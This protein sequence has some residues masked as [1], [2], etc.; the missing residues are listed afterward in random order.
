MAELITWC[1]LM[2]VGP[3]CAVPCDGCR[4]ASRDAARA[5]ISIDPTKFYDDPPGS[6]AADTARAYGERTPDEL[7]AI[8]LVSRLYALEILTRFAIPNPEHWLDRPVPAR[9]GGVSR[10]LRTRIGD[11]DGWIC[12]ICTKPVDPNHVWQKAGEYDRNHAHPTVEHLLP[13]CVGGTD[14]PENLAIAHYGCNLR[15]MDY[16]EFSG[17]HATNHEIIKAVNNAR[18]AATIAAAARAT[19]SGAAN[20]GF[21][22][23]R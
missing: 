2:R 18:A 7:E 3:A 16:E 10:A 12:G 4:I 14:D 5:G 20:S 11:R 15:G 13:V 22:Q 8:A 6:S 1:R 21:Q 17:R 23:P 9:R 19:A